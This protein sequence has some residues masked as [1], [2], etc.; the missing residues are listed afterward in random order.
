MLDRNPMNGP[1]V[2]KKDTQQPYPGT[3]DAMHRKADHGEESYQGCGK[4]TGLAAVITGGDSGIGRAVAIAFAKE[5]ADVA[6]GYLS[7]QEDVDA[8]ETRRHVEAAGRRCLVHRFDVR[9]QSACREFVD[10]AAKEFG[11]LD[12]LVNNAAYQMEQQG[13]EE[14]TEEQ[15]DRT[16]RT[17][18]F[19]YIYMAQ[20]ALKHLKEGGCIINTG[21]VTALEGNPGLIDYSATKGAIHNF[22]L[23]LAQVVSEKGIR[24]NAVA[25]GPVWTPLI[26]ATMSP[27]KVATFGEDTMWKRPAQPI[28]LATSYV[29][30]ASADAR[31]I[32]G[33]ILAVTGKGGTR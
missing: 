30:L 16:F 13:I 6:I 4:L 28:E 17:N 32:S 22:T 14:L 33:E 8:Q 2:S 18:I 27:E 3:D 9:S 23:T 21:S 1:T 31:Y 26:P 12:I 19:G 24:V 15:I 10:L 7:E 11:R 29:F 5:G 25:P 20:A